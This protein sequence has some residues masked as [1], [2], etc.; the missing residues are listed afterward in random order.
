MCKRK[1]E[2]GN[3]WVRFSNREVIVFSVFFWPKKLQRGNIE[4]GKVNT[5]KG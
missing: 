2:T 3:E 1:C 5:L 4:K